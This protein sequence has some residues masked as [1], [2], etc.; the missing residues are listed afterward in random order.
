MVMLAPHAHQYSQDAYP[1]T[2]QSAISVVMITIS[3][4]LDAINVQ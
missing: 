2:P 1:A 4:A 3:P